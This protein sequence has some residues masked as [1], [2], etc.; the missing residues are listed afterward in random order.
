MS[1]NTP[2]SQPSFRD[3]ASAALKNIENHFFEPKGNDRITR[4]TEFL[5]D[6]F[7]W[8]IKWLVILM[9]V[10]AFD[11]IILATTML[12]PKD[13]DEIGGIAKYVNGEVLNT[14]IH[15][16]VFP[17]MMEWLR[18]LMLLRAIWIL[19]PIA[20]PKKPPVEKPSLEKTTVVE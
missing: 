16:D 20:L 3:A 18:N 7:F 4:A 13:W 5:S 12:T 17:G 10:L 6:V 19:I 1:T 11:S 2:N 15:R 14:F 8:S 9:G